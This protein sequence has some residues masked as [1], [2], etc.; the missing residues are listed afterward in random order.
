MRESNIQD[1]I[2]SHDGYWALQQPDMRDYTALYRVRMFQRTGRK[3]NGWS[4]AT[5]GTIYTETPDGYNQIEGLVAA[6]FAK[7]PAVVIS[8]GPDEKGDPAL[9]QEICNRWLDGRVETVKTILRYGLL[10]PF[11]G[12]KLS[13]VDAAKS[14]MDAVD[15]RPL[16]PWDMV[17]DMDAE[18][19]SD[20]RYTGHIYYIDLR[21]AK[22]RWPGNKWSPAKRVDYL[23]QI[24]PSSGFSTVTVGWGVDASWEAARSMGDPDADGGL[25]AYVKIYEIYDL[26]SD[27]VLWYSPNAGSN[28]KVLKKISG[29]PIRDRNDRPVAPIIPFYASRD[30]QAPLKGGSHMGRIYDLLRE[31]NSVLTYKSNAVRRDNR[32]YLARK[33]ALDDQARSVL[34]E[35]QD[36]TIIELELDP[37]TSLGETIV[38]LIPPPMSMDLTRYEAEIRDNLDRAGNVAPFVR[39]EATNSTATEINMLQSYS[40]NIIGMVARA[41]DQAL[42]G[43]CDVY[44]QMMRALLEDPDT[45]YEP[46]TVTIEGVATVIS[47]ASLAGKMRIAASDQSSTPISAALQRQQALELAPTLISLG[48]DKEAVLKLLVTKFELPEDLIPK[49]DAGTS[50]QQVTAEPAGDA[51]AVAGGTNATL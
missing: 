10:Y 44:I 49:A 26:L 40:S 21:T 25:L 27:E 13:F 8:S 28:G 7:N 3:N 50:T 46:E 24:D 30:P 31:Y 43:M 32:Q 1:I 41:R 16:H 12:V 35:N 36:Q 34:R 19:W 11:S 29:I 42:E 22:K 14:V 15:I 4:I 17:V 48:A 37:N 9:C 47:P 39:G 38:P 6:A 2:E 18:L 23:T 51:S 45:K 20:Q 33:D 5:G